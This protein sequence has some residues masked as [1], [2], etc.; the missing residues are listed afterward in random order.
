MSFHRRTDLDL[1]VDLDWQ[2]M[3]PCF[4]L[5]LFEIKCFINL[6]RG[7]KNNIFKIFLIIN[8]VIHKIVNLTKFSIYLFIIFIKMKL[9]VKII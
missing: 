3:D 8:I 9:N 4:D 2:Q 5:F 1:V 7:N 6:Y